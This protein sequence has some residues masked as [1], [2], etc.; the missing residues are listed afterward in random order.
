MKKSEMLKI[1]GKVCKNWQDCKFE[2]K[3]YKEILKAIEKAGMSPPITMISN[4]KWVTADEG[5]FKRGKIMA[6]VWEPEK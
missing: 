5:T 4:E 1:I 3:M 2:P 6:R